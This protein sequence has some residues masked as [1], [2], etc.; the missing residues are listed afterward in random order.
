VRRLIVLV[1]VAGCAQMGSPP[2][3]PPDARPPVILRVSPDTNAVNARPDE[4]EI[5]YDE[6]INERPARASELAQV[7]LVSPVPADG[8][9]EV[10]WRRDRVEISLRRGW[11]AN[12]TYTVTQLPG[13]SDLRGNVD[14]SAHTFIFST[15]PTRPNTVI[16]GQVFDWVAGRAAPRAYVEAIQLPD[17]LTW[18]T[19]ADSLGRFEIPYAPPGE[20]HL[21]ATVDANSNRVL[22][23]RELFDSATV[24]LADSVTREMLAFLHDSVGPGIGEVAVRDTLSLRVTFDRPLLPSAEVSL[25]QFSLKA[26]DSTVVPLAGLTL[27]SAFEKAEADSARAR[28]V[29]DSIR[30]VAVE[31]SI[32]R[33]T[34]RP[35]PTPPA[36]RQAAAGD[37]AQREPPPRPSRPSPESYA[38]LRLERPLQP[39]TSYRLQADSLRNLIGIARSSER[40][41]TT[42]AAG[43]RDTTD[44]LPPPPRPPNDS[45][46]RRPPASRR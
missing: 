36:A 19:Y 1:A 6:V 11:R 29:A 2:G 20:Y 9:I 7:Y 3:G 26:A 8:R 30:R 16:R 35:A 39:A 40:V 43:V 13:L 34:G 5:R 21:R 24:K 10:R 27:G 33:A 42:P 14:T 28:A 31:D 12:T 37:T 32:R 45:A 38:I 44:T 4:F 22:D 25:A 41:F 15:G 46:G 17:S 18:I 23:R